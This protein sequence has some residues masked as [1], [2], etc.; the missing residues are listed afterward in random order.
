[1][2]MD[3]VGPATRLA[4][5]GEIA[6]TGVPDW[7]R[8]AHWSR[9]QAFALLAVVV[10]LLLESALVP[11]TVGPG[12]IATP[13][14]LTLALGQ[15]LSGPDRKPRARDEDLALYDTAIARIAR[16]ENYYDFIV[17][18]HRKAHYPVR[19]AVAVR[20]P[21]LAILDAWA[22]LPGQIIAAVALMLAVLWAWWQRLGDEPGGLPHRA[23]AV[24]LLLTGAALGLNRSYFVLHELWAGMLMAL[25]FGLHRPA[26]SPLEAVDEPFPG[27]WLTACL[28]AGLALAIR[29]HALP[30]VLLMA[31]C[32]CWRRAWNEAQ[33]W[34]NVLLLF[35]IGL[36]LHIHIIDAQ[37]L[38]GDATGPSWIALRGLGG[39]LSDIVLSSNLRF[40]PHWAAGPLAI[41]MILG[42]AG[43][44]SN[45]GSFATLLYLGYGAA[46]MIAGRDNNFYWGAIIAPTMFMGLAFAP[47]AVRGLVAAALGT[48]NAITTPAIAI[49]DWPGP[50]AS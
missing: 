9:G 8:F 30:F 11:I 40:F 39:W 17:A 24:A 46:F 18:Q 21:T 15:N 26:Q 49:M 41:L 4:T 3:A 50:A 33:A 35:G 12:R 20:L 23:M 47:M 14:P 7:N 44:R 48:G 37:A 45:A 1:M 6:G 28:A 2:G 34:T 13:P 22:G 25:A 27:K 10:L 19:P 16:G 38:P 36:A 31:A 42:W 43:W 32:A 5:D 29:E